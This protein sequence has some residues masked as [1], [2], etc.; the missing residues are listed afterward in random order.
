MSEYYLYCFLDPNKPGKY[1]YKGLDF[2]FL[3]E[4]FYIGKGKGNRINRH[5]HKDSLEKESN[6]LKKHKILKIL[7][8]KKKVIKLKLYENIKE[9]VSLSI[10]QKLIKK[11]GRRDLK[12]GPL[13]NMSDGGERGEKQNQEKRKKPI[14][15]YDINGKK[16]KRFESIKEAAEKLKVSKGCISLCCNRKKHTYKDYL[17]RFEHDKDVKYDIGISKNYKKII[18]EL[19]DG[20]VII[21]KSIK[22]G[23]DNLGLKT[24]NLVNYL[25]GDVPNKNLNI[26]YYDEK[27][28]NKYKKIRDSKKI[29]GSCKPIIQLS[30][31]GDFI[32]DWNSAADVQRTYNW[33]ASAILSCCRGRR[34][35]AYKCKW[36]YKNNI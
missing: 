6:M 3:Y 29:H 25:K 36:K 2:C 23:A 30:K 12:K 9:N 5:T 32:R 10:E 18:R 4:P 15:Q 24:S 21:Y 14:I 1:Y 27:Y 19:K 16:I 33:S 28:D 13:S 31:N 17:W 34:K 22:E 8:S 20:S 7:K 11:I 26:R 35:T